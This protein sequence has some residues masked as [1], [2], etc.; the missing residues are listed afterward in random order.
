MGQAGIRF[1]GIRSRGA[2]P[3]QGMMPH[4]PQNTSARC[5][6]FDAPVT[7]H[8]AQIVC[9][10]RKLHR[11]RSALPLARRRAQD[12]K[13]SQPLWVGHADVDSGYM[14]SHTVWA[15]A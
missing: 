13:A 7:S 8:V 3:G 6:R 2:D 12:T 1:V 10:R 9:P 4:N 15:W 5:T 11:E 14:Q